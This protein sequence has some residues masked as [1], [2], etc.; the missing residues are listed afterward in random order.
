M[1]A[2]PPIIRHA[3]NFR[4]DLELAVLRFPRRHRYV[5]GLELRTA[6][7]LVAKLANKA[8]RR[9]LQ[10]QYLVSD[11]DEAVDDMK[12]SMQLAKD[13]HAFASFAQFEDLARKLSELGREVGGWRKQFHPKGQ[14]GS[15]RVPGQRAKTLSTHDAS[16]SEANS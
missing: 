13:L 14:N 10:R 2:A 6:A 3:S 8:W 7:Q 15:A 11:L 16:I 1:S 5:I 4:R 12:L 9:P